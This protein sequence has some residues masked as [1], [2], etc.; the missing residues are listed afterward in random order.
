MRGKRRTGN[1]NP[2]HPF[3]GAARYDRMF[4]TTNDK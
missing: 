1:V 2:N 3:T 4:A